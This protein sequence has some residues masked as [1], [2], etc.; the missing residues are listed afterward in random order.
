MNALEYYSIVQTE[1]KNKMKPFKQMLCF[2]IF[3]IDIFVVVVIR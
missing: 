2:M 1:I 3:L